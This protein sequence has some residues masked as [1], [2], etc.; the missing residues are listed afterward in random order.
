ML[1][2]YR[3][4]SRVSAKLKKKKIG[5]KL[6]FF[7]AQ[8]EVVGTTEQWQG[9]KAYVKL[10]ELADTSDIVRDWQWTAILR[11]CVNW[12]VGSCTG[13]WS[14]TAQSSTAKV[15]PNCPMPMEMLAK[16]DVISDEKQVLVLP[17]E[18]SHFFQLTKGKLG[19]YCAEE[20]VEK[21]NLDLTGFKKYVVDAVADVSWSS[22]EILVVLYPAKRVPRLLEFG[23]ITK[24]WPSSLNV[25]HVSVVQSSGT[26]VPCY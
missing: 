6:P 8:C 24:F 7:T 5:C 15:S 13:M 20:L 3:I 12:K 18:G 4:R 22:R 14:R 26:T 2:P 11:G 25:S 10:C 23:K 1:V 9:Q 21:R 19:L 16:L 17:F